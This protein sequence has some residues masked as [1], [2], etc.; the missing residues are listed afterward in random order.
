MAGL[1][2]PYLGRILKMKISQKYVFFLIALL[3]PFGSHAESGKSIIPQHFPNPELATDV[4]AG[5]GQ[6]FRWD[7]LTIATSSGETRAFRIEVAETSRQ[8]V[9]GLQLRR[10]L[11]S[12]TGMLFDFKVVQPVAMWM[13]NTFISL[14]M[15]FIAADGR[16]LNIARGTTPLS[17]ETVASAGPV[18]GV[19]EIRAGTA[20]RLGIK[21]GDRVQYPIFQ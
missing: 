2:N 17:L 4:T 8:R 7:Q 16:I 5:T 3:M 6:T 20:D 14:D 12:G 13:K 18:L 9:Q 1:D 11:E 10:D 15:L 21:A 19:L